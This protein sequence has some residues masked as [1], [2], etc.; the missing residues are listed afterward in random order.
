MLLRDLI[1]NKRTAAAVGRYADT[2]NLTLEQ[3]VARLVTEG[4]RTVANRA[5]GAR[6]LN[7]KLTAEQRV[8]NARKGGLASGR[9]KAAAA[10]AER[11]TS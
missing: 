2:H 3:A 5:R 6:S 11:V 8:A 10:A 4:L 9:S 7:S 1:P